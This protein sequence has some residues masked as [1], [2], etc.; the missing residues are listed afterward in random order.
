MHDPNDPFG[1]PDDDD[2]T[3]IRPNP[4]RRA[5]TQPRRVEPA[6][7]PGP[8]VDTSELAGLNPLEKSASLL[9]NLLGQIRNTASHPNPTALH[10]QLA[11]EV[12]QFES[13]AQKSGMAPE[14]I[15]TARYVL[16]TTVDEFVLSTPWGAASIFRNQSLLRL[17]HQETSG[18]EK[19]FLLLDKLIHDPAKNIDLLELMF[20]CLALGFQGRYRV[21]TDGANTLEAIRENLYRTIRNYRGDSETALSLH[22]QG[23]DKSLASKTVRLPMWAIISIVLATLAFIFIAFSFSLNRSTEPL[24]V[25]LSTTGTEENLLPRRSLSPAPVRRIKDPNPERFSLKVFLQPEISRGQV[26]VDE[27]ADKTVVLIRGDGLFDSA[28]D[29]IKP[30]F[31]PILDRIGDGL[32]Q[33][34]GRIQVTGHSDNVP[35]S[36]RRFPSNRS[37]SQARADE[38]VRAL[39]GRMNNGG[40]LNALGMA[41]TQPIAPN[42]TAQG[43]AQNRRVEIT[44]FERV[45]SN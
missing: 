27:Q 8:L 28:V 2:R 24:Y 35:I 6:D 20:V 31:L 25:A 7:S 26:T 10:Q 32:G 15:F 9:L 5:A 13:R 38:V 45:R 21:E 42:N 30:A 36:T 1:G 12:R 39:A 19:F 29:V 41:D 4:G 40:R 34:R 23:V 22:W 18:G 37:L 17:F 33:T 11:G 43:R 44:V 14:T 16:C 3:I